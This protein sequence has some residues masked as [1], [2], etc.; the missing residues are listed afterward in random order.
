MIRMLV[1]EGP[2]LFCFFECR[3]HGWRVCLSISD[4]GHQFLSVK[5]TVIGT[6][7]TFARTKQLSLWYVRE[8]ST[9]GL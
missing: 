7:N 6:L 1:C 8:K 4:I 9:K 5:R 3:G 2:R